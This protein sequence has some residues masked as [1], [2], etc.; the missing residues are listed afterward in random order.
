MIITTTKI[1]VEIVLLF[2]IFFIVK[3]NYIDAIVKSV[4]FRFGGTKRLKKKKIIKEDG[5]TFHTVDGPS[6]L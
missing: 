5:H 4:Q 2:R 1:N 3:G 6:L